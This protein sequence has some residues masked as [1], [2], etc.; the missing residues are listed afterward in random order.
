MEFV[1]AGGYQTER[2]WSEEGWR[3]VSDMKP[4]Q[5]RFWQQRD[6]G[7]Y[8]RLFN[9]EIIMPWDWPWRATTMRLSHSVSIFRR[10]QISQFDCLR[11]RS[12]CASGIQNLLTCSTLPMDL[13]GM[14]LQATSTWS[15][16]H[17]DA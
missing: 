3:W 6:G 7:Y 8:L 12:S 5:P 14:L 11:K 9:A 17:L 4:M 2:F 1:E 16:G 15:T 10:K 13:L